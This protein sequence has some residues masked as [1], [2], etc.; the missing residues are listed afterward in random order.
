METY[1]PG[2][3]STSKTKEK[4]E[5]ELTEVLLVREVADNMN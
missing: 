4:E 2:C 1:V 3:S 5:S